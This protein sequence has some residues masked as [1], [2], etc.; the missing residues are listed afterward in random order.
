[1][2]SQS[3]ADGHVLELAF[4]AGQAIAEVIDDDGALEVRS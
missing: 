3:L 2:R 4:D 1:M